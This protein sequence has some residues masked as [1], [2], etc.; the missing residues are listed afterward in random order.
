MLSFFCR[1]LA[2]G[3]LLWIAAGIPA[4]ADDDPYFSKGFAAY[5]AGDYAGAF[6]AFSEGRATGQRSSIR[7]LGVLY[8]YGRGTIRDVQKAHDL[9]LEAWDKGDAA[10]GYFLG[11]MYDGKVQDWPADF[12][13]AL[14]WF[15]LGAARGD[16]Q[17]QDSLGRYLTEGVAGVLDMEEGAHWYRV[18]AERGDPTA[19][20]N[21][22]RL[23]TTEAH[24]KADWNECVKWEVMAA[25]TGEKDAQQLAGWCLMQR[26]GPGDW[27]ESYKWMSL[28]A[29]QGQDIAMQMIACYNRCERWP[30]LTEAEVAEAK[31][32]AEAFHPRAV[33]MH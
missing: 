27:I 32:R 14:H 2:G 13:Q 17:A 25:E 19:Q 12:Q 20:F 4:L 15:R 8:V 11:W 26:R 33:E 6:A 16:V 21:L 7:N 29:K 24:Y 5:Q 18:A 9:F 31:S 28:A 10:A 23:Y 30:V 22:G 3:F 1:A